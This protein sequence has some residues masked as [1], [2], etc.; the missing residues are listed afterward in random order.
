MLKVQSGIKRN[1]CRIYSLAVIYLLLLGNTHAQDCSVLAPGS[2]AGFDQLGVCA[3]VTGRVKY[4]TFYTLTELPESAVK[5]E[6]NWGEKTPAAK[7]QYAVQ[8]LGYDANLKMWV[9][10][11]PTTTYRY[12]KDR[13]NPS[14]N[15]PV[16]VR[17]VINGKIC[18]TPSQAGSV[19]VWDKDNANG[20]SLILN[21][22]T[23][24]VCAGTN[25]SV[26]FTDKSKWNCT[27]PDEKSN[28]NWPK[29]R[30][31]FV[32]GTT[33]TIT[34]TVKVGDVV[35]A[36]SYEGPYHEYADKDIAPG[37]PYNK[38][39]SI[40][41]PA[42]AAVGEEFEV[43]LNNWNYCNPYPEAPIQQKA[44]IKIIANPL[45]TITVK[46]SANVETNAFCPNQ[47]VKLLGSYYTTVGEVAA[48][49]VRYDWEIY[50]VASGAVQKF[51][52][53]K[54]VVL[55]KGFSKPGQQ[56]VVLKITNKKNNVGTCVNATETILELIDAPAVQSRLNNTTT[57]SLAFCAPETGP[58][59]SKVVFSH[60]MQSKEAFTYAY[61]L[62]KRNSTAS[63]PDSTLNLKSG[64]GA[65]QQIV[66]ESYQA[67]YTKPGLYRI[68]VVASNNSTG[69][70]IIEENEVSIYEK[71]RP[72]FT[73]TGSC[74]GQAV[75]IKDNSLPSTV[76]G[77]SIKSWEWDL[78]YTA[79]N[80]QLNTFDVEYSGAQPFQWTYTLPGNYTIALRLT[81]KTGCT[82]VKTYL[83]EIK[84]VPTAALSSSYMG[85]LLCPGDTVR[86]INEAL[87]LNTA[88]NFPEGVDYSL[89][90]SDGTSNT[91][92]PFAE[93][94]QQ[95][96]YSKFYNTSKSQETYT[97]RLRA[98]ARGSNSCYQDSDPIQVKV[99]S[100]FA[101][102]Y[103]TT[104]V[105]NPFQANCSP[106]HISFAANSATQNIGAEKYRWLITLNGSLV[107]EIVRTNG[108]DDAPHTLAYTF[109]N[110]GT[111]Y[112]DYEVTLLVEK[113]GT[114]M[115]P[116]TNTYRIYPNPQP[117]FTATPVQYACDSVVYEMRVQAPTGI[118]NYRWEFLSEGT[119]THT[120]N[121][122][123]DDHFYASFKRPELGEPA[124]SYNIHLKATN[125][126]G[127]LSTWSEP[128]SIQP[129]IVD[130]PRLALSNIAGN[131][132]APLQATFRNQT[133]GALDKA[134]FELFIENESTGV[135]NKI[136]AQAIVGDLRTAFSYTF[137]SSGNYKVYLG[138]KVALEEGGTC[139]WPLSEP[140]S[141][142]VQ[143]M[144]LAKF[145]VLPA[146]GCGQF[147]ASIS[148]NG[149]ISDYNT[150][151]VL[152]AET[153]TTL[154][155]SIRHSA[156]TDPFSHYT[157]RNETS[158]EKQY[159]ILLLAENRAGCTD[160]LSQLVKVSPQPKAHFKV[161]TQVCEPFAV[162]VEH[163]TADNAAGTTY[164]WSWGDGTSSQGAHPAAHSY[165]NTT[166]HE[167]LY[168]DLKLVAQNAQ[169]CIADSTIRITIQPRL[170]AA[171]D[172][173]VLAGCAP[174]HIQLTN[175]SAG[176]QESLSGWYVREKGAST[177][178]FV[179]H[180]LTSQKFENNSQT[181]KFYELMYK[182]VNAGGCADSVVK[183]IRVLPTMLTDFSTEP[184][185]SV[186]SGQTIKFVNERVIPGV[187][188]T[189]M[190]G[191]GSAPVETSAA[192][193]YHRYPNN[194]ETN[195]YYQVSLTAK[196]PSYGC[197]T[198][199]KETI[200]VYPA[201]QLQLTARQ[202]T[203]C[204]P[205]IPEFVCETKNVA[206]HY[207]YA[208]PQGRVD[209]SRR[210][211]NIYD[212]ALFPNNSSSPITY[213]VVYVGITAAGYKD[214]T[215]TRVVIYPALKPQFALDALTK[216]LPN[217][218][219]SITN[220]TPHAAAWATSWQFGDG[221][222]SIQAQPG[223]YQYQNF[224]PFAITLTVSN[225]YCSKS[226]TTHVNVLDAAPETSF[227]IDQ[228]AGCWPVTVQ[229]R[230]TSAYTN[231]NQYFWDFGDG[232]G[233]STAIS[234]S[235][236]YNKP[237]VYQVSLRAT[238]RTG[239]ESSSYTHPE[240]IR[241]YDSPRADFE[242][243]KKN[244]LIPEEP[245]YVAN[246]TERGHWYRWDFG[247]GTIYQ[248]TDQF[249]PVHYYQTPGTYDIKLVTI[250]EHG[251]VDSVLVQEAVVAEGG[252]K[253]T[254]PNAFTPDPTGPTG[255]LVR[256]GAVNDLFRPII[257]GE[258]VEYRMQIYNRWGEMLY[259]T[260]DL[261]YGWDGYYK[262]RLCKAD[263]YIYK[264]S[265]KFSDGRAINKMGDVS[266]VR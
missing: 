243:H 179:T 160:T 158:Q 88:A 70:S 81:N 143:P 140:V 12:E 150:W 25:L 105:Y 149:L 252:G 118:S 256:D 36:S 216:Q 192:E 168:Y 65:S 219:F 5:V 198:V 45:P 187:R 159:K 240:K 224:G 27:P 212:A 68:Q 52:D 32:Y 209:Y 43:T 233:T 7:K 193:V 131:G 127:C 220:T 194:T 162:E 145:S 59:H 152:D 6:I 40:S 72:D 24:Y 177:F 117:Q 9:Y 71:P 48:T 238:N 50:D 211:Q 35:V 176:A 86:F 250:S 54:D 244:L 37:A 241:V 60:I 49:D 197:E 67:L 82:A 147:T 66:A 169:G 134:S 91:E 100:G 236:T 214:S 249:E 136:A 210:L 231:D 110:T 99:N 237:G 229:F 141:I 183:Q 215:S 232:M 184:G 46:N 19:T 242:V 206:S 196:D 148:K 109:E 157:F 47:P 257:K 111:H 2:D 73:V 156:A 89:H 223:T 182:A 225:G 251:C 201:L 104:P 189:W 83:L 254:M 28:I 92:I 34:G 29:R 33:N 96:D 21:P 173:D 170:K 218:S 172:T 78:D 122:L 3:P 114:C 20:G 69:C 186:Y 138:A 171:F 175:K 125:F 94:Q 116:Y 57:K 265:I 62:F 112:L 253:L 11:L 84:D 205:D 126:Y 261:A 115:I 120:T 142:S 101:A 167:V 207:W 51:L 124:L 98:K 199:K 165:R 108:A 1:L 102:A 227:T 42:T 188:Y 180:S 153:G 64:R 190:F 139:S 130:V 14:C 203:L 200:T 55:T 195:H 8:A 58:V 185:S 181:E 31:Q 239:T 222:S 41:I 151:T 204:L 258:V 221:N 61:H 56:R 246:Y 107:E 178:R 95:L 133:G 39:A 85:Q 137:P 226:F 38:S 260:T 17:P 247:D 191:D 113:A 217:A 16:T 87:K 228:T 266:L 13:P 23:Y 44:I 263:V 161:N 174:L 77:D 164:T 121:G 80:Q 18:S 132:C 166:Y 155:E 74:A 135:Q 103:T 163:N 154:Y 22:T 245:V 75:R 129:V 235:Y 262:G 76:P 93:G 10:R 230:N 259:Q 234:P 248:G 255:G 63:S 97:V 123:E 119:A 26:D 30:V 264:L 90:I 213:E 79:E 128:I 4:F 144:P 106:Y 15:Y 146:E 202:D 53:R 208:G